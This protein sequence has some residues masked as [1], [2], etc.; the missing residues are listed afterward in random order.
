MCPGAMRGSAVPWTPPLGRL[1][2]LCGGAPRASAAPRPA[3]SPS[4]WGDRVVRCLIAEPHRPDPTTVRFALIDRSFA[5][6]AL[7]SFGSARRLAGYRR[8][9]LLI[10]V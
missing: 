8:T 5:V 2:L 4:P 6:P 1:G 10:A 9:S 7:A 3:C